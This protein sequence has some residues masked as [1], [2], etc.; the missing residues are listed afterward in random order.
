MRVHDIESG[1]S[2][3]DLTDESSSDD[4]WGTSSRSSP[5]IT[6][7]RFSKGAALLAVAFGG[8]KV[9]LHEGETG[10][11]VLTLTV[12]HETPLSVLAWSDDGQLL[13]VAHSDGTIH[14]WDVSDTVVSDV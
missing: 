7:A 8:S 13:G 11:H 10:E 1:A 5:K 14:L 3:Y 2:L 12:A 6:V 4:S 9:Q